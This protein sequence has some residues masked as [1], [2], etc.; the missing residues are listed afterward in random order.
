MDIG[1]LTGMH[2]CIETVQVPRSNTD[3]ISKSA[4]ISIREE[5][6]CQILDS[7]REIDKIGH[8]NLLKFQDRAS[9]LLK[10]RR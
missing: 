5:L 8:Q 1:I 10:L 6:K 3:R 9:F 4:I 2:R 7:A